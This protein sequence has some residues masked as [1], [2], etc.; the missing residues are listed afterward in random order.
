MIRALIISSLLVSCQSAGDLLGD[1]K[2]VEDHYSATYRIAYEN[3]SLKARLLQ[4]N[5][6]TSKYNWK[7]Q[8]PRYRFLKLKRKSGS[9]YVDA[10]SGETMASYIVLEQLS[11]DSLYVSVEQAKKEWWTRIN[12]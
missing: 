8:Q 5:D 4:S 1:W 6:G 2:V 9:S 11:K 12:Q 10:A 3:D 7:G